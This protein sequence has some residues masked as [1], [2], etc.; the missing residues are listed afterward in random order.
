MSQV[1]HGEEYIGE[2]ARTIGERLKEH[3]KV[4]FPMFDHANIKGH[5]T[6]VDN[7]SI[8]GRDHKTAQEP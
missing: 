6:R 4:P 1:K 7:F 2:S 5:H 8:V 3:L